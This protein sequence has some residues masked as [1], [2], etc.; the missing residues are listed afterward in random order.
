MGR[1]S[2]ASILVP[3]RRVWLVQCK[4]SVEQ[5][6]SFFSLLLSDDAG[7]TYLRGGDHVYIH[8]SVGQHPE[9]AGGVTGRVLHPGP[10]HAH[11]RQTHLADQGAGADLFD[12]F[13]YLGHGCAK[14]IAADREANVGCP[15]FAGV[16]DDRIDADTGLG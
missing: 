11:S 2:G 15:V 4:A 14:V 7:D 3:V 10:H 13:F 12:K 9:H 5:P 1:G 8:L 16:L 6:N